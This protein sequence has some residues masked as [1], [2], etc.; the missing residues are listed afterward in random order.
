M[1]DITGDSIFKTIVAAYV[2]N[3]YT[4]ADISGG[5]IGDINYE[6]TEDNL[7]ELN[8]K[9]DLKTVITNYKDGSDNITNFS[10]EQMELATIMTFADLLGMKCWYSFSNILNYDDDDEQTIKAITKCDDLCAKFSPQQKYDILMNLAGVSKFNIKLNRKATDLGDLDSNNINDDE[11]LKLPPSDFYT[12]YLYKNEDM[13]AINCLSVYSSVYESILN[14]FAAESNSDENNMPFKFN[15][16]SET[17]KFE[18]RDQNN[19]IVHELDYR[20]VDCAELGFTNPSKT[21]S[22][23]IRNC[24]VFNNKGKCLEALI[25]EFG[26]SGDTLNIEDTDPRI[27]CKLLDAV[28]WHKYATFKNGIST[29]HFATQNSDDSDKSESSKSE[30]SS[31]D[32]NKNK[33]FDDFLA[34]NELTSEYGDGEGDNGTIK[35]VNFLDECAAH[36]NKN[37]PEL[38]NLEKLRPVP[39]LS[40]KH[41][42][43]KPAVFSFNQL[44]PGYLTKTAVVSNLAQ[45]R[46]HQATFGLNNLLTNNKTF[47]MYGGNNNDIIKNVVDYY[48]TTF[49]SLEKGFRSLGKELHKDTSNKV[50]G[51]IKTIKNKNE[52][53]YKSVTLIKE[54]MAK[55]RTIKDNYHGT[56]NDNHMKQYIES[57]NKHNGDL[58]TYETKILKYFAKCQTALVSL[59]R[60]KRHG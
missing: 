11:I 34:N 25:D 35:L 54:Y 41:V 45:L 32:K 39:E 59:M 24:L 19:E 22:T 9:F 30:S 37:Y 6:I 13:C 17:Q 43:H 8:K 40:T 53:L 20:T 49:K 33:W 12:D 46:K 28:E 7:T 10:S 52:D 14:K 15:F 55:N 48:D 23:M 58:T 56:V 27:L 3:T 44:D 31:D 21:C 51:L 38:L 2:F 60:N 57:Y 29:W 50:N 4:D 26:E 18:L 16:N 5:T 1:S 36:I 47:L 42:F